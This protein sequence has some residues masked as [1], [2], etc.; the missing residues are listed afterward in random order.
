MKYYTYLLCFFILSFLP[1]SASVSAKTI[2][3]KIS[4]DT[5][6]LT[7][8]IDSKE[9]RVLD[10][11]SS[12]RDAKNLANSVEFEVYMVSENFSS[13]SVFVSGEGVCNGFEGDNGV[14][15]TNSTNNYI[16]PSDDSQ[17]YGGIIGASLYRQDEPRNVQY[18]PVYVI[19]DPQLEQEI[20]EREG[21]QTKQIIR[22]KVDSNKQLL[23]KMVCKKGAK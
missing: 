20:R 16:H 4:E 23:D 14:D 1:L 11:N 5:Q 9:Q 15:F 22:D 21:R 3:V 17:Y 13:K 8:Y 2:V 19:D 7:R 10:P 6:N 12:V 18:V